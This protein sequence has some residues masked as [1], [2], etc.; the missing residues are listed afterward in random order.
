MIAAD[1]G[2]DRLPKMHAQTV[3]IVEDEIFLRSAV[4]DFLRASGL[5][6]I[7]A[8]NASE[9]LRVLA[10][11]ADVD[12]V[13]SDVQMPGFIN[14]VSLADWVSSERPSTRIIL[15]TGN[16]ERAWGSR[17]DYI[18]LPKPYDHHD[19]EARIRSLLT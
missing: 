4:A 14:G 13:F 12:L 18:V 17:N 15:T 3:L 8:A 1:L 7:E 19:L 9:A 6:V 10:S 2:L 5:H 11:G 16:A